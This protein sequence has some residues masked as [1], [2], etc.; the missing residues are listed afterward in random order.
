MYKNMDKKY[1]VFVSSTYKDLVEERKSI[2][3]SLSKS[4]Y[5]PIG[6]EL[7]PS[8]NRSLLKV[9]KEKI[10]ECDYYIVIICNRYGSI[11]KKL[12]CS[13]TEYELNYAIKKSKKPLIFLGSEKYNKKKGKT[14][15]EEKIEKLKSF[16]ESGNFTPAYF[17]SREELNISLLTSLQM[18][19]EKYPSRG[20][21]AANSPDLVKVH[22]EQQERTKFYRNIV[23]EAKKDVL[24]F[25]TTLAHVSKD[26]E[27]LKKKLEKGINIRMLG[28]D[29]IYVGDKSRIDTF[30]SFFNKAVSVI[31]KQP[32][33]KRVLSCYNEILE[34]NDEIAKKK[35]KGKFEYKVYSFFPTSNM[36]V[37][38]SKTK[39]G[40]MVFEHISGNNKRI[41]FPG[42]DGNH[43]LFKSVIEE[44]E[45]YWEGARLI[46]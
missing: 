24:I 28:L 36:T 6:M 25:G 30:N 19:I 46:F 3:A 22:L 11:D 32:F 12:K 41:T 20:W 5:I 10:D 7:F 16:V 2:A 18:H 1:L 4:G 8:D 13:Y 21:I 43:L 23:K 29:P 33:N 9:I 35:Y 39:N 15:N 37:V 38:D 26:K 40:R 34:I 44:Y 27:S 14:D 31:D 17:S 45:N 42:L